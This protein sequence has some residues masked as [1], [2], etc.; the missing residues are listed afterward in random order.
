MGRGK[1]TWAWE[2]VQKRVHV[3]FTGE[4]DLK[5]KNWKTAMEY[6]THVKDAGENGAG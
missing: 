2:A 5:A 6:R 3:S 4:S 1:S